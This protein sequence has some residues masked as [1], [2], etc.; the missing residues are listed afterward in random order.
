MR[1]R[2]TSTEELTAYH[3]AGHAVVAFAL[4]LP[5]RTISIKRDT[6]TLGRVHFF[7]MPSA[8]AE[9]DTSYRQRGRLEPR[10]M[11]TL[12]GA[13]AE[14]IV[15]GTAGKLGAQKDREDAAELASRFTSSSREQQAYLKWL[16]VRTE[17]LLRQRI[18]L[19]RLH[20]LAQ[21]L[22]VRKEMTGR[23][24]RAF[25]QRVISESTDVTPAA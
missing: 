3:E 18:S 24:C 23:E 10:I 15:K 14:E 8:R 6:D 12:A 4:G 22:L 21:E 5:Y 11:S 2:K 7:K 13:I 16:N 19:H 9:Y 25:L 17:E 20:A 1:K